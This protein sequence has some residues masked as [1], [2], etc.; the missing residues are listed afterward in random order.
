MQSKT[1]EAIKESKR[2]GISKLQINQG[3]C[4]PQKGYRTIKIVAADIPVKHNKKVRL[5]GIR[6]NIN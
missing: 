2:A 4:F 3:H 1:F 5:M 6:D